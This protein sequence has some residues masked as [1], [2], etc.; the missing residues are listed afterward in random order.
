MNLVIFFMFIVT[1]IITIMVTP[2]TF[3]LLVTKLSLLL[4]NAIVI[5]PVLLIIWDLPLIITLSLFIMLVLAITE[6]IYNWDK[7]YYTR[8]VMVDLVNV[9]VTSNDD[10]ILYKYNVLDSSV[11]DVEAIKKAVSKENLRE[12]FN[13]D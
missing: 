7:Y 8:K 4:V 13:D 1:N 9:K 2:V 11:V 10:G 12:L 5:F 6:L 3:K